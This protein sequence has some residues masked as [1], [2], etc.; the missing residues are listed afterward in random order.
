MILHYKQETGLSCC[1]VCLCSIL[2]HVLPFIS[3]DS[4][5]TDKIKKI[6]F[7][8]IKHKS[9][10]HNRIKDTETV[11]SYPGPTAANFVIHCREFSYSSSR[12]GIPP[13]ARQSFWCKRSDALH[14]LPVVL[15]CSSWRAWVMSGSGRIGAV[16]ERKEWALKVAVH[17][18]SSLD[19]TP[20]K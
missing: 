7:I 3:M 10:T 12:K 17:A 2:T 13:W 8:E 5:V 6:K 9:K 4:K 15:I 20:A 1:T 19:L 18:K 14:K 16:Q 11:Q